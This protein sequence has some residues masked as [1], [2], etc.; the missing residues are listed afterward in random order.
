MKRILALVVIAVALSACGRV[1]SEISSLKSSV[2]MLKRTVTL[3]SANGAV[4]KSWT[5]TN[6]IDYPGAM[7]AFIDDK[8]ENVR[9]SGTV[10]VEGK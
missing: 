3:Y 7:V 8:G 2:G 1:D 6:Q 5:T 9:V 4:I 10:I